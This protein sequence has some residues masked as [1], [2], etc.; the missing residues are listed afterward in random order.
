MP[1]PVEIIGKTRDR[2]ARQAAIRAL[3][4]A[5][6]PAMVAAAIGLLI[7]PIG[8]MTWERY[9]YSIAPERLA[10]L[11]KAFLIAS[12]LC[13]VA[14]VVMA[15]V[16]YR[17][18]YD[19]IGAAQKLDDLFDGREQIV[20]LATLADPSAPESAKGRR[21]SLF[22]VL[23]RRALMYFQDF[24]PKREFKLQV[25]AP[26]KRATVLAGL[27]ALAMV[28]ATLGLMRAPSPEQA[29]A[30]KLRSL[31]EAIAKSSSDPDDSA[32]VDKVR[33]A[34]NALENPKVPREEKK[35]RIEQAMQQ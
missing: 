15:V 21:T 34:A 31:A 30:A 13:L 2:I 12:A 14:G 19:F 29:M 11:G 28:V 23:W 17:R 6:G 33:E 3:L 8:R 10:M 32:L 18:A 1:N 5:I 25:G 4:T 9:G 26:I 16:A 24:D 35:K 20:T 7:N 27:I 22:P